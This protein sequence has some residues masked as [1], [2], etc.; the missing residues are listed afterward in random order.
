MSPSIH[1]Q[2]PSTNVLEAQ[3][4]NT[5]NEVTNQVATHDVEKKKHPSGPNKVIPRP[6]NPYDLIFFTSLHD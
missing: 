4:P 1:L 6:T 5:R 2:T 3:N